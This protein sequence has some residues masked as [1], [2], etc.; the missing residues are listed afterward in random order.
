[1][2]T[3]SS[4][5]LESISNHHFNKNWVGTSQRLEDNQEKINPQ[6]NFL[7]CQRFSEYG[8][9][10]GRGDSTKVF[11][12][13]GFLKRNNDSIQNGLQRVNSSKPIS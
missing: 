10:T 11:V 6:N 5:L 3:A 13:L 8:I 4:N 9:F 2:E 12:E 7:I 1:M